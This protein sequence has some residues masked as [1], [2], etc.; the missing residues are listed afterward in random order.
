MKRLVLFGVAIF[1]IIIGGFLAIDK[2]W[3][4][5][6]FEIKPGKCLLLENKYCKKIETKEFYLGK[7]FFTTIEGTKIYSPIDGNCSDLSTFLNLISN[8]MEKTIVIEETKQNEKK[9]NYVIMFDKNAPK[10]PTRVVKKGQ[11]LTEIK[12]DEKVEI[13]VNIAPQIENENEIDF[14][15]EIK[16]KNDLVDKLL[17]K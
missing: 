15:N 4:H 12:K 5:K 14:E 1:L 17:N 8:K 13:T 11:I 16:L 2:V 9:Y 6:I 3:L 7:L 10:C